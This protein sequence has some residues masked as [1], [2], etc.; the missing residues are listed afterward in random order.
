[1]WPRG[2]TREPEA[3]NVSLEK[4]RAVSEWLDR[5]AG[6][7]A[8]MMDRMREQLAREKRKLIIETVSRGRRVLPCLAGSKLVVLEPDGWVRPCEMISLLYPAPPPESGLQDLRLGNLREHNYN[9]LELLKGERAR[10]I[11]NFIR[12]GQCHCSYECAALADLAFRPQ[13]ALRVFWKAV[14]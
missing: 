14:F 5:E 6:R 9:L 8:G 12:A 10:R 11:N 13:S 3:K 7:P 4:F 2:E 1:M